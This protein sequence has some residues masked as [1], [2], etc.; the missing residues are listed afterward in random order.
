MKVFVIY[1]NMTNIIL[2]LSNHSSPHAR[3]YLEA[4]FPINRELD[5]VAE[6][7]VATMANLSA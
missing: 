4:P 3:R 5:F 2:K 6:E 7:E 1:I